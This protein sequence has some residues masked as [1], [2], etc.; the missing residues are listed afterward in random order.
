MRPILLLLLL[1]ASIPACNSDSTVVQPVANVVERWKIVWEYELITDCT[2]TYFRPFTSKFVVRGTSNVG[3]DRHGNI[4]SQESTVDAATTDSVVQCATSSTIEIGA[5]S[6]SRAS[7]PLAAVATG[8]FYPLGDAAKDS[9]IMNVTADYRP[10]VVRYQKMRPVSVTQYDTVGPGKL[11][12][13][14]IIKDVR[15]GGT[16]DKSVQVFAPDTRARVHAT[17]TKLPL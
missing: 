16:L 8:G 14:I 3:L 10:A 9:I 12:L 5:P 11:A 2:A 6:V 4:V 7:E 17:L 15:D 13:N 1:A